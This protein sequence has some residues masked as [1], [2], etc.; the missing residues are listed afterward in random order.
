MQWA[1]YYADGSVYTSEDGPPF[2]GPGYGVLVIW[3]EGHDL[4]FNK[5]FYLWHRG[6]K[7]WL[8]TDLVGLVDYLVIAA[9][10]IE[11]VKVGRVVPRDA[12]KAVMRR[13]NVEHP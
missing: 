3:Q 13:V 6:F 8:E 10:L 12:F 7:C 4:L 1:I 5:D 11:A 2:D 9:P